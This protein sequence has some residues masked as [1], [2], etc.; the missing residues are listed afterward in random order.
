MNERYIV[1]NANILFRIKPHNDVRWGGGGG[2]GGGAGG[3]ET[4]KDTVTSPNQHGSRLQTE[5]KKIETPPFCVKQVTNRNI[6]SD[7]VMPLNYKTHS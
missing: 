3:G 5:A 2:L 1:M 7:L 4:V 6:P